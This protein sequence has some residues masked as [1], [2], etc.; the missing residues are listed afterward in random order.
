MSGEPW[1]ESATGFR[2]Q[3]TSTSTWNWFSRDRGTDLKIYQDCNVVQNRPNSQRALRTVCIATSNN[4]RCWEA[5]G[6]NDPIGSC[7][8]PDCSNIRN[9][10]GCN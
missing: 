7:F 2:F 3:S 5:P 1:A 4:Y 6:Q 9:V 8:I 10:W